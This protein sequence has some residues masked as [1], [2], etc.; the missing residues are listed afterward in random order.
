MTF[1]VSVTNKKV[2]L[3]IWKLS[4][5]KQLQNLKSRK[6]MHIIKVDA[7]WGHSYENLSHEIFIK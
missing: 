4:L 6:R 7:V 1:I 3:E 2:M 5:L